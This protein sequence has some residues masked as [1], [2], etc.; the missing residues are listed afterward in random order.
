MTEDQAFD[1]I[2]TQFMSSWNNATPVAHMNRTFRPEQHKEYAEISMD[3]Q[4]GGQESMGAENNRR[5][6]YRGQLVISV[7][8]DMNKGM[9]RLNELSQL[10]LTAFRG[11]DM[12]GIHILFGTIGRSFVKDGA[13][14][15]RDVNFEYRYFDVA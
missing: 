11:K 1:L 9:N 5:F 3:G 6:E 7:N 8:V 12:G 4:S 13:F 2:M 10:A 15:S 14:F